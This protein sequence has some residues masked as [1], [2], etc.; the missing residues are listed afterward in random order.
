VP[1]RPGAC[2]ASTRTYARVAPKPTGAH[3]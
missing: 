3:R 2:P 1:Q